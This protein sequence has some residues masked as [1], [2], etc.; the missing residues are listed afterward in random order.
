MTLKGL[1]F[2]AIMLPALN[3][4]PRAA[5]LSALPNRITMSQA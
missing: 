4:I 3:L 1:Y 5:H 2:L